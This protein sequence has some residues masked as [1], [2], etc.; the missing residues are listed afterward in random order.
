MLLLLDLRHLL[1]DHHLTM[2]EVSLH[3]ERMEG[4]RL[5]CLL[6]RQVSLL[7]HRKVSRGGSRI[8][9]TSILDM[10]VSGDRTDHQH[11]KVSLPL[12]HL[13]LA[14]QVLLVRLQLLPLDSRH[15]LGSNLHLGLRHAGE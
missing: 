8:L 15:R 3:Q 12:L 13:G 7:G 11:L 10:R 14:H 9:R 2:P 6:R 4:V 1:E 5:H